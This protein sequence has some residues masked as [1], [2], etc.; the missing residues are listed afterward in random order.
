MEVTIA[1]LSINGGDYAR[2][3]IKVPI[4]CTAWHALLKEAGDCVCSGLYVHHWLTAHHARQHLPS[5]MRGIYVLAHSHSN[6]TEV[7][8]TN[9]H[10]VF[11]RVEWVGAADA[12]CMCGYGSRV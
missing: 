10:A 4:A 11:R 5:T 6:S 2:K 1:M 7:C 9:V 8:Q 12:G 3:G